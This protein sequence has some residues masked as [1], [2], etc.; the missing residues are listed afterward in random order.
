MWNFL[1][2]IV[3]EDSPCCGEEFF[4]QCDTFNKAEETIDE[5]FPNEK[6]IYL[7]RFTDEEAECMGYDTY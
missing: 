4:V 7:G 1:F 3:T 6:Y 5:I 2:E